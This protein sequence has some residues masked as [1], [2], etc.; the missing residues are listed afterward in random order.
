MKKLLIFL[1]CLGVLPGFGVMAAEE[2]P[3]TV[4]M[5]YVVLSPTEDGSANNLNH[6][7]NYTNNSDS[8]FKGFGDAE[9]V[10]R[11]DLPEG[12]LGLEVSDESLG[13]KA[14][15]TG[16]YTTRPI[17]PKESITVQYSYQVPKG[18]PI[19]LVLNY[20]IPVI[21][22]L[23]P[24]GAGN[25]VIEGSKSTTNAGL[26]QF[27]SRNFWLYNVE[28]IEA[29]KPIK[30]LH[31]P[32]VQPTADSPQASSGNTSE[33]ASGE[34]GENGEL[35]NVTRN[36]PGFHNPGHVRMWYQTPLKSFDPHILMIV[37]GAILIAGIGYYSYFRWKAHQEERRINADKEEN[38][39]KQL[40]ARQNAIMDKI[41]ELEDT[42][43]QG[44][45][46]EKD[47][48]S[49]LTAYKQHLVQVKVSLRKF[50]E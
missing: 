32:D 49:K 15:N 11:I 39:F 47:Y 41:V 30:I 42:Y 48:L 37:L 31:D 24:E 50:V 36:D 46:S 28:G 1:L 14:S 7:V 18:V 3:L 33:Q 12:A 4:D 44:Q 10:I 19:N 13:I 22:V 2:N 34:N 40:I 20:S 5:H 25:L 27:E 21:Q 43:A 26:M 8:E 35:G 6:T 29:A 17:A 16:F 38:A 23:I 45:I 9:G